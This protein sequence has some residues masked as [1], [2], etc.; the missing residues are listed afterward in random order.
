[1]FSIFEKIY[2]NLPYYGQNLVLS[3]YGLKLKKNRHGGSYRQYFDIIKSNLL[4]TE[5]QLVAYQ[6]ERLRKIIRIALHDVPYYREVYM[7][8]GIAIN[9]IQSIDD[10]SNIPFLEKKQIRK[11]PVSLVSDKYNTKKLLVIHTTGT[12]GTPLNIY[13][14]SHNID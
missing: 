11:Q 5:E 14:I 7:N 2:Q 9:D 8:E 12:T 13:C 10:L 1:V 3:I 6:N 4:L